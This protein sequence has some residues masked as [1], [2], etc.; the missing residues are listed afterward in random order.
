MNKN[1]F[2][3]FIKGGLVPGSADLEGAREL[4]SL[5][6]WFHSAH[7]VLL[8]GLRES[9][10]IK[11]ESQL[12]GSALYV[13]DR[14]ILYNYLFMHVPEITEGVAAPVAEPEEIV[15]EPAENVEIT[16]P[17]TKEN[18][19]M[20]YQK[21]QIVTPEEQHGE[22]TSLRSR[23]DL[24]AEIEARLGEI[25]EEELLELADS[26]DVFFDDAV[27]NE[28]IR[29]ET[30]NDKV[31][32]DD[33]ISDEIISKEIN[34][35]EGVTEEPVKELSSND[36]IDRFIQTS[37][38]IERMT[39]GEVPPVRDLSE[40]RAEEHGPFITET[41][42]RIYV[43]QGYYTRAINI[44]EKLTLQFPEKSAYFASRIEKIKELIK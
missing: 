29:D 37:P 23:D 33:V 39:P 5:F 25:N 26:D 14:G 43:N 8:R 15:P 38:R 6:P 28:A 12:K 4:T 9:S 34:G 1:D 21:P 11:F 31:S 41:L 40:E 7:L 36:L 19:E 16:Y 27:G 20:T 35:N 18:I 30:V 2:N 13:A 22:D 44:Y 3:R 42:A 24:V 10:D 17:E 32:G